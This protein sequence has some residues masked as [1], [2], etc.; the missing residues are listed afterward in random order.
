MPAT[1]TIT[2]HPAIAG[3]P[4]AEWDA[5]G[6]DANPFTTHRFLA[7]LE[8]SGSVGGRT[9]WTP[10]HLAAR[11]GGRLVGVAPLY[12]KAHSQ[13]EYIFDHAWA[14]AWT[15]AGGAYYPKLQCAVPF[16]P[17]TGPRLIAADPQ[18]Q[19]GLLA[20]MTQVAA[21][22]DMSGVHVTFCT[23]AE[24]RLGEA[25]GFL[26]RSTQQFHWLNDG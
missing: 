2:V 9:G 19:Q 8:D 5:C 15:R 14:Q 4:A 17:V 11:R 22:N 23:G 3:I 24:R 6:A 13:G 1:L 18:V 26:G 10:A 7:A 16:T 20:A 25:A 12:A 21:Q